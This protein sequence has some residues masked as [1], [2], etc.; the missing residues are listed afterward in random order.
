VPSVSSRK[1]AAAVSTTSQASRATTTITLKQVAADIADSHGLMKKQVE[2]VL[3]DLVA[4]AIRHL[5]QGD[6]V[7]FAGLGTLYVQQDRPLRTGLNLSTGEIIEIKGAKKLAKPRAGS[8]CLRS[9]LG[10]RTERRTL[11]MSWAIRRRFRSLAG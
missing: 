2:A 7:R 8:H 10:L 11:E 4:E 1:A 3:D 9:A 5:R 6:K